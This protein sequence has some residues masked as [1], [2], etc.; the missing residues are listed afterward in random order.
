MSLSSKES[1]STQSNKTSGPC[2][3]P[4][5]DMLTRLRNASAAGIREISMPASRFK[6]AV[7]LALKQHGFLWSVSLGGNKGRQILIVAICE[8]G[9][10]P[11]FERMNKV[12]R[13]GH[14]RYV[15]AAK[16]RPLKNGR[17][18]RLVSTSR[19]L[20]SAE[21]ARRQRL[22]GELICEVY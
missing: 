10:S 7:A 21:E 18:L 2:S 13:P 22:G 8:D 15:S 12:S 4:V 1:K 3:D 20:L 9:K 19:G 16:L 11:A 6:H 5:A 14:R 17:G